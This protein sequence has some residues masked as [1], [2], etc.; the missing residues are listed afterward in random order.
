MR[1]NA[2]K[3]KAL[4]LRRAGFSYNEIRDQVK[5]AKSTLSLWLRDVRLTAKQ[6]R[7]LSTKMGARERSGIKLAYEEKR[8]K[9]LDR[10]S[11]YF[12]EVVFDR[13]ALTLV[14]AAL[15][16]AEGTKYGAF[17]FANSDP[18]MVKVYLL[19]LRTA[20]LVPE[21]KISFRVHV[22]LDT[23]K[24]LE[25]VESFWEGIVGVTR[26]VFQKAIVNNRP[27]SSKHTKP[28]R[29]IYGTLHIRVRNSSICYSAVVA[30]LQKM[31]KVT[32][33][34]TRSID[35]PTMFCAD[36]QRGCNQDAGGFD[37]P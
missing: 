25:E 29:S 14:G 27:K 7:R 30:L 11:D 3:A 35:D 9:L 36:P 6:K 15:Y 32:N 5:V 4:E 37:S 24:T 18:D 19:W 16:W 13:N 34:V 28:G 26:Q 12:S 20:L 31:G 1:R 2:H 17:S 10:A 33:F 23:G 21:N 8:K 22:Y